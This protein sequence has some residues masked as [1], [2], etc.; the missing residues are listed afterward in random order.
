[1]PPWRCWV[2]RTTRCP[3]S[4]ANHEATLTASSASS[5]WS[6]RQAACHMV[7]RMASVSMAASAARSMV[8]WK[9]DSGPA[10][11]LPGVEV[12]GRL[13]HGGLGH[14]DLEG[15]QPGPGPVQRIQLT[16]SV[17]RAGSP[18]ASRSS[19]PTVDPVEVEVGVDLAVGGDGPLEGHA[20]GRRIDH[21]HHHAAVERPPAPGPGRPHGRRARRRPSPT[22]I[23]P[24]RRRLGVDRRAGRCRPGRCRRPRRPGPR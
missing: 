20:G 10:E 2:A 1:M 8:P 19:A 21:R 12:L 3:A 16:T 5:P 17:P 22:A 7:T 9:V 24:R 6:S 23:T 15:A 18:P 14:P 11:L 13:G 4:A